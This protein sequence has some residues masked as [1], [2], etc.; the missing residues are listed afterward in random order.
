MK[1]A[2]LGLALAVA[3]AVVLRAQSPA[4]VR[5]FEVAD[6]HTV[7]RS[8]VASGTR[9]G[10]LR[11][12]V[13]RL[14]QATMVDLIRV[15]YGVDADKVTGGPHWLEVDRF[16]LAAKVPPGTNR[17]MVKPMLQALLADRFKL[18]VREEPKPF[19]I[20]ALVVAG[21]PRL[22]EAAASG[23]GTCQQ[24][25]DPPAPGRS[26]TL[27]M[28][29]KSTT[30]PVFAE[31]LRGIAGSD[32]VIDATGISGAYDIELRFSP[33]LSTNGPIVNMA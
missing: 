24:S 33:M 4:P 7:T 11:D 25:V 8:P 12:G 18:V 31:R 3:F 28:S 22:K 13:F 27:V 2:A 5:S 29:C 32:P 1:P 16:D 21:T 15:A 20:T 17:E 23:P 26:I 19:P 6:V 14:R 30:M 10:S 9:N